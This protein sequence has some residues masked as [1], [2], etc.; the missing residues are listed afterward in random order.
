[1]SLPKDISPRELKGKLLEEL[2]V[3]QQQKREKL[4]E[5]RAKSA[6]GEEELESPKKTTAAPKK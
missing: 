3:V 1:L 2:K 4:A 6:A 5:S